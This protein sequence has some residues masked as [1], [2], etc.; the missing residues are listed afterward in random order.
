[1][2]YNKKVGLAIGLLTVVNLVTLSILFF[3]YSASRTF[4][5]QVVGDH[6]RK[7]GV[8]IRDFRQWNTQG[9]EQIVNDTTNVLRLYPDNV[10]A[11]KERAS[12]FSFLDESKHAL[13]D[14]DHL[15]KLEPKNIVWYKARARAL[16]SLKRYAEAAQTHTAVI[17][18]EGKNSENL[19]LRA[20]DY[21]E[22]KDNKRALADLAESEKTSTPSRYRGK[23]RMIGGGDDDTS[24]TRADLYKELGLDEKYLAYL[25]EIILDKK[26]DSYDH[27]SALR[28][29]A[30]YWLDKGNY[31]KALTDYDCLTAPGSKTEQQEFTRTA[32]DHLARANLL[33]AMGRYKE[34]KA[35]YKTGLDILTREIDSEPRRFLPTRQLCEALL[36]CKHLGDDA[37]YKRLA[38]KYLELIERRLKPSDKSEDGNEYFD[39]SAMVE[40]VKALPPEMGKKLAIEAIPKITEASDNEAKEDLYYYL[41]DYEAANQLYKPGTFEKDS[42]YFHRYATRELES[43][44][45][46]AAYRLAQ[47]SLSLAPDAACGLSTMASVCLAK[48]QFEQ[49]K[50]Y[51]DRQKNAKF[52]SSD[53]LILYKIAKGKGQPA[54]AEKCLRRAAGLGNEEAVAD[55]L[56]NTKGQ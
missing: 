14:Y 30:E 35:G 56:A 6:L 45:I 41:H 9:H 12:A 32:T 1:M 51:M 28:D 34:A 27:K 2:S 55:L 43:G 40:L 47:K 48:G 29:R 44:N 33:L 54:E 52:V 21:V 7:L 36:A 25:N 5:N 18:L 26:A 23:G 19:I 50:T 37:S 39:A 10:D 20:S 3:G 46:E 22:M 31:D 17:N 38:P 53:Y 4:I 24:R 16:R 15:I 11:L 13:D 42:H 49:A 8:P